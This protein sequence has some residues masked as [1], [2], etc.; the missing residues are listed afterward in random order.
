MKTS[1]PNLKVYLP[2]TASITYLGSA[3]SIKSSLNCHKC[4]INVHW[5]RAES[6]RD[7]PIIVYCITRKKFTIIKVFW[8]TQTIGS[9]PRSRPG[10][11]IVCRSFRSFRWYDTKVVLVIPI[12]P[13]A[14]DRRCLLISLRREEWPFSLSKIT[15]KSCDDKKVWRGGM[16]KVR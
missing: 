16:Q 10:G 15:V 6:R 9:S 12:M 7:S 4:D 3:A 11:V 5:R 13:A 14:R 1:S 2:S 8:R